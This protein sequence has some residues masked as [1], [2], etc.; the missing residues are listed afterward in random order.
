[1]RVK[2]VGLAFE[3]LGLG[4]RL[5][6]VRLPVLKNTWTWVGQVL[7]LHMSYSAIV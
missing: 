1:M 7:Q 3:R 4:F 2:S 5:E 6:D